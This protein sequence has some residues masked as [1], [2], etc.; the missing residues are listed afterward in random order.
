[1]INQNTIKGDLSIVLDIVRIAAAELVCVGH[2]IAWNGINKRF[3]P[4]IGNFP[5]ELSLMADIGVVLF[6]II[7]GLLIS[8]SVFSKMSDNNYRFG[9]YF[10]DRFARIYSGLIPCMIVILILDSIHV[11]FFYNHYLSYVD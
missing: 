6:F 8:N 1:M 10:I 5:L 4:K 3:N 7:S 11:S 2:I 9:M